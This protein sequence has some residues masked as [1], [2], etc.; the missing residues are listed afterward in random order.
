MEVLGLRLPLIKKGDD[1]PSMILKA[2]DQ[3][4]GLRDGDIV[5]VTSKAVSAAQ[6]RVRDLTGIRPSPRA[7]KIA[8]RT[9]QPPEFVEVVLRE[10]DEVLRVNKGAILTI[11]DGLI[12]ANAGA[13]LSNVPEGQAALLPAKPTRAAEEIRRRFLAKKSKVGV[14]ISDSVVRPLRLGT[15]GQAIGFAG[16]EPVIDSRGRPD[17]Y[18]KPLRMTFRAIAD[19]LATAAQVVMGEAGERVP[20]AVM[21]DASVE[22]VERPRRSPKISPKRCLYYGGLKL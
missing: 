19:Q 17:I 8:A 22:L 6:G 1:L 20:V 21:R 3:I 10:A 7:K 14:V 18:G 11:K 5:V 9:G 13:D 16:I 4:G 12:C 15:V 2:A